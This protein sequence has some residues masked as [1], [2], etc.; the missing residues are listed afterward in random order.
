[1]R[2]EPCRWSSTGRRRVA[3][4]RPHASCKFVL[5]ALLATIALVAGSTVSAQ[6]QTDWTGQFSSNWFLSGN[7]TASFPR[8]T[9]DGN[10][11]TVT[12]NATVVSSPGAL[13]E[14]LTV[15]VH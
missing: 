10:I 7:W 9:T 5:A 8:Q 2:C 1:M 13:A 14:D 3:T 12:P 11:N 6:A 4:S 15:G